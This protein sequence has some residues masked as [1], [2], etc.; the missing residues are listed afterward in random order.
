MNV[1][2]MKPEEINVI[3]LHSSLTLIFSL[4]QQP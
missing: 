2:F 3:Y 1:L 4:T